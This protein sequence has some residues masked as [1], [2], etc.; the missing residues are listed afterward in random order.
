[1]DPVSDS[2]VELSDEESDGSDEELQELFA[3]G[4]LQPGLNIPVLTKKKIYIN[5][6][7]DM[8]EKLEEL[9]LDLDW[10]ES[11][12]VTTNLPDLG[13]EDDKDKTTDGGVHDD[14]KREMAF[15][16]QAQSAVEVALPKLRELGVK[17]RRP[18]TYFAEMVKSDEHMTKVS[19]VMMSKQQAAEK[20]E[21]ARKQR[22]LKKYGKKVQRQ[23][24]QRKEK[25]K[26]EALEAVKRYK[27]D[28][29]QKP[30]FLD[31]GDGDGFDVEAIGSKQ[32]KDASAP[33]RKSRRQTAKD[34]KFGFGGKKR[35]VKRN[36]ADSAADMSTFSST[37]HSMPSRKAR[38]GIPM[39]GKKPL[40]RLG[41]SRRHKQR[42][43]K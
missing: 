42:K 2:S 24:L 10:I 33:T 17:T 36:T 3:Q 6:T 37:K 9:R 40:K 30:S 34:L 13:E 32:R 26:K 23:V 8:K 19:Q 11:L 27:K 35:G 20:S 29:R 28:K 14:F 16:K 12:D 7:V 25:E 39:K 18:A 22:E 5:N 38:K 4:K 1:M 21:K 15:Y 43:K 31:D 41:K